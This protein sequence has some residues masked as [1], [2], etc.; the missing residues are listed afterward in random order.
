MSVLLVKA[1]KSN[2]DK[3]RDLKEKTQNFGER[4]EVSG[5]ANTFWFKRKNSSPLLPNMLYRNIHVFS[6]ILYTGVKGILSVD[7]VFLKL[8]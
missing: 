7:G 1:S 2:K 5:K 3:K 4:R 8:S 6:S